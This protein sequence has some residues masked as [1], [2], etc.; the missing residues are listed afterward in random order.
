MILDLMNIVRD[1]CLADARFPMQAVHCHRR[2]QTKAGG[3][4][5]ES[6]SGAGTYLRARPHACQKSE[7]KEERRKTA[8]EMGKLRPR[9]RLR[10][11]TGHATGPEFPMV[12][13][14]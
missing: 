10:D 8:D 13:V 6:Y 3:W 1:D 12:E 4:F 7:D 5:Y 14:L 11:H 2:H 9:F